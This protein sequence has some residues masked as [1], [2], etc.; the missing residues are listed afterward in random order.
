MEVSVWNSLNVVKL[1]VSVL[2][3]VTCATIGHLRGE[4]KR[5]DPAVLRAFQEVITG[6]VNPTAE[7]HIEVFTSQLKPGMIIAHDLI[8]Q[9][10]CCCLPTMCWMND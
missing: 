3:P 10:S 1:I 6:V 4:G 9:D 5:Y 7:A 8:G 2:T